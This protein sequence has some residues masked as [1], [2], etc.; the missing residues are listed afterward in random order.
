MPIYIFIYTV[1]LTV[2][3]GI[4]WKQRKDYGLVL[5]I[6]LCEDKLATYETD[7]QAKIHERF[8]RACTRMWKV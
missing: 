1:K 4:S 5:L 3:E 7:I 8:P 6:L 2:A